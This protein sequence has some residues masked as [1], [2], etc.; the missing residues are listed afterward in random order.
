MGSSDDQLG[1]PE[2][3]TLSPRDP[4]HRSVR[5][6]RSLGKV[7]LR[8]VHS[9]EVFDQ[10]HGE[11]NR[12]LRRFVKSRYGDSP[13][14]ATNG[15]HIPMGQRVESMSVVRA[16]AEALDETVGHRGLAAE[17]ERVDIPYTTLRRL[18][19]GSGKRVAADTIEK[20]RRIP[21]FSEAYDARIQPN[22]DPD[23]ERVGRRLVERFSAREAEAIVYQLEELAA[24]LPAESIANLLRDQAKVLEQS[25]PPK[26]AA[27]E[28]RHFRRISTK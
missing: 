13:E 23:C 3:T 20:L 22:A 16:V 4:M 24:Y 11:Q 14:C 28:K 26:P 27:K 18:R 17:A 9:L 7:H 12:Q 21:G 8:L 25:R 19:S 6:S 2:G 10:S 5:H 15:Y 1:S